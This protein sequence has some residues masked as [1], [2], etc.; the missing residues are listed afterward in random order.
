MR[1][2]LNALLAKEMDRKAFLKYLAAA[3]FM[4]F[5]GHA[6]IQSALQANKLTAHSGHKARDN[7]VSSVSVDKNRSYGG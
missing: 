4:V 5:G 6:I 3:G 7:T 1:D 2:Q